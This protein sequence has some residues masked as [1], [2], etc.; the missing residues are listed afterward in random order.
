MYNIYNLSFLIVLTLLASAKFQDSE[1]T[2]V[3]FTE[4]KLPFGVPPFDQISDDDFLPAFQIAINEEQREIQTIIDNENS[5]TFQ[6]TIEAL[7]R[8]GSSLRRVENVFH[9][10]ENSHTNDFLLK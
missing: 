4:W 9:A 1:K 8:S 10:I 5:P 2:N 6:N 3:F 7:E